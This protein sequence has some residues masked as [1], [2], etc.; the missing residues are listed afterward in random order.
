MWYNYVSPNPTCCCRWNETDVTKEDLDEILP[1]Y[2]FF[3]DVG[4]EE[5]TNMSMNVR[6]SNI[7]LQQRKSMATLIRTIMHRYEILSR[8]RDLA[9]VFV[10]HNLNL[11][12]LPNCTGLI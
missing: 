7:T 4:L 1:N 3:T 12:D 11:Q 8:E 10:Q 2:I 6:L 5:L 9:N